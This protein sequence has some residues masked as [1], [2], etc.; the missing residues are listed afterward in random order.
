MINSTLERQA[1][2]SDELMRRLIEE[3][4]GKKLA[5]SNVNP[6]SCSCSVN[7][8]QTN[9]QTSRTLTDDT[10]MPNPLA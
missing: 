7:F 2:S 10:T 8:T 5:N 6:S 1:K 3:W 9:R 4:D